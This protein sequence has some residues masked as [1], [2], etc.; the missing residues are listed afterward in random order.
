MTGIYKTGTITL[1]S[2]S[3][4]VTG[5]GT[6]FQSVANARLGDLFSLDGKEFF[7]IYQV[8]TETQLRIRNLV[9]GAK[10]QGQ[11]V[12]AVSYAIVR[13]FAASTDAQIASDVVSLQQ[14]WHQREREMTEWFAS[15]ANYHQ[16]TDI[17]GDKV[18]VITPTGLNNLVDGPVNTEDFGFPVAKESQALDLNDFPAGIFYTRPLSIAHQPPG[19]GSGIKL[20]ITNKSEAIF[21]QKIIELGTSKVRYR[22]ATTAANAELWNTLGSEDGGSA[23]VTWNDIQGDIPATATRWPSF[24]EVTGD[25][26]QILPDTAKR[27]PLFS[28]VGG[29]IN[30]LLAEFAKRWPSFEEVTG[31]I[32]AVLPETAK[33]WPKYSEVGDKPEYALGYPSFDKV[34]GVVSVEQLPDSVT[35]DKRTE[36]L[37][38]PVK[39]EASLTHRLIDYPKLK[40]T[41]TVPTESP[42][43][44]REMLF[45]DIRN[46]VHIALTADWFTIPTAIS[47]RK[48]MVKIAN[49]Y[50]QFNNAYTGNI[51]MRVYPLGSGGNGLP[52]NPSLSNN[53]W[54]TITEAVTGLSQ[55]ARDFEGIIDY[56]ELDGRWH[57][58]DSDQS[59]FPSI[60]AYYA[61]GSGTA[62]SPFR[63]FYLRKEG[64]SY[65]WYSDDITPETPRSMGDSWSQDA[66]NKKLFT[67]NGAVG[68]S[69][70]LR[71]FSDN[72]DS[73]ELELI[74]KSDV[75]NDYALTVSNSDPNIVYYPEI[76][77][78][79]TNER[80]YFKRRNQAITGTVEVES[81]KMRLSHYG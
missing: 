54:H 33:R 6:L 38:L 3:N 63:D 21:Y 76:G 68:S 27:W 50:L 15:D 14:R 19:F 81:I 5:N 67:V 61:S 47:H 39:T 43:N 64:N 49:R 13:N 11:S 42:N 45:D 59:H 72:Y 65:Y 1:N 75:D 23:Q 26:A 36:A 9:T 52:N 7:E 58:F 18:L 80:L 34:T 40:K 20:V 28:E 73:Y 69:D 17:R 25:V 71:F 56:V 60:D 62:V 44:R 32:L 57:A 35:K 22:I 48:F 77:R 70:A 2:N 24:Q 4:I 12:A 31:D 55:L 66:T 78:Y 41:E 53:Q 30:N 10:Y 74:I 37:G 51:T 79:I 8:D 16:I 29:D 46:Q